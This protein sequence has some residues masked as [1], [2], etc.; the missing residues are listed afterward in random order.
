MLYVSRKAAIG[1]IAPD[2]LKG[3]HYASVR[4]MSATARVPVISV[5]MGVYNA[6]R[7]VSE[8]IESVLNQTFGDFEFIVVD[9]GS[10]DRTPAIL[11]E[12]QARDPRLK[13]LR[14]AHAG[15]VAAANAGLAIARAELIARADAD[16]VCLP[17]RFARQVSYMGDHPECVCLGSRM[18]LIE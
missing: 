7:Y 13:V 5:V 1:M 8:A 4:L 11:Q 10:T 6:Q 17:E 3:L 14:I 16:D 12:Y 2:D 18:L 9:D 15:I